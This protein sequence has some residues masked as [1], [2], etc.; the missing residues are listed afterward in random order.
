MPIDIAGTDVTIPGDLENINQ[1]SEII[2][3]MEDF[4]KKTY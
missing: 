3:K 2:N 1:L 4:G